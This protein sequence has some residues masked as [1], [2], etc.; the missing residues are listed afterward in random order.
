MMMWLTYKTELSLQFRAHFVDLIFQMWSGPDSFLT[1]FMWNRALSLATVLWP[2]LPKVVQSPQFAWRFFVINYLMMM[3]LTYKT[4]LSLQSRA[5]FVDLIFQ[6]W[7]GPTT[8]FNGFHVKSSS[9]YSLVHILSTSSSKGGPKSSICLANLCDQLLDDDVVDIQNRAL[10]TVSCTFCRPHLPNV[11]RT[12]QFFTVFMWNRALATVLSTFC[13]PHLPKVVQSPQFAWRFFVINYLMMMWLTYKTEL[14]L[15]SRA[16]FVDL[17]F[18]MWSGPTTVFNGFHVKSSSRYSLV[19]ILSTSSSKGGPNVLNLLGQFMWS[20]TWWWCGWHTKPSSRYS[21]VHI[22]STSSSKCGPDPTVFNGFHVKSSSRYSLV[23]I[24]STSS[25]KGGPKSSI[26]LANVC[27]QLLDDDVV[28]IQN[29][30]LAT[31]SCTFCRPHLPN[32]VRT[33]Q[34]LTVFMWNRALATVSCGGAKPRKHRPSSGDHMWPICPKKAPGCVPETV[35]KPEVT[36][37]WSLTL[38]VP[39]TC[40]M[41][42]EMMML[43]PWWWDS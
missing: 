21:F 1:V 38:S 9:R 33:R 41:M 29:R 27:D 6:M 15:Q 13:R 18:R 30:A 20:T 31:V 2:H 19:H 37:S 39:T 43:L 23:H 25:S 5:H 34:F 7:S 28:D 24:L 4:E 14:S 8:V 16:H 10:A 36:R 35:F 3:W 42:I 11:V 17:I 26:C 40:D 32:V 12:R 22:L